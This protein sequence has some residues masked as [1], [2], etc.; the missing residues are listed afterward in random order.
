MHEIQL[1]FLKRA[2]SIYIQ[3]TASAFFSVIIY[4]ILLF[5]NILVLILYSGERA[6]E[7]TRERMTC[8]TGLH[9]AKSSF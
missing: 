9:V 4:F 5:F 2:T 6:R 8:L 3:I 7:G 1:I